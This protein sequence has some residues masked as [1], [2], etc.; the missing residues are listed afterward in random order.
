[1]TKRFIIELTE[2]RF[3]IDVNEDIIGYIRYV[4]PSAH[5]D[6][7]SLLFDFARRILGARVY[8]PMPKSFTYVVLHTA[9]DH[10]CAIASGQRAL[11]FKLAAPG[12]AEAIAN[13][14][15]ADE[16]IGLDWVRFDTWAL[17]HTSNSGAVL[18]PWAKHAFR[19]ATAADAAYGSAEGSA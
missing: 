1:M 19:D 6:V 9:A 8:C 2:S 17:P 16:E 7:G 12:R 4:N 3:L 10:I 18:L 13:G 11:S 14:A 15:V 5:S